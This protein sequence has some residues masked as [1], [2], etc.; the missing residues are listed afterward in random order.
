MCLEQ[1]VEKFEFCRPFLGGGDPNLV[2]QN[3]VKFY[4]FMYLLTLKIL[5]VKLKRVKSLFWRARLG[6][7]LHC[8]TFFA[9]FSFF[10]M[11]TN[12]ETFF[13]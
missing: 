2:H 6:G 9:T 10:L 8:G 13:I 11:S 5:C 4:F 1:L 7:N 12:S 3:F